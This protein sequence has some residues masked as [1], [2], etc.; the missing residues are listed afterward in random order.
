MAL[1]RLVG[2]QRTIR[3][4]DV[5][6]SQS[7]AAGNKQQSHDHHKNRDGLS[8]VLFDVGGKQLRNQRRH[9]HHG[10]GSQSKEHHKKSA[11]WN[12]GHG[13]GSQDGN[14]N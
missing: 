1:F 5:G 8:K 7:H 9:K 11:F 4:A 12:G 6:Y 14:V 10:K 3:W 13:E 2:G